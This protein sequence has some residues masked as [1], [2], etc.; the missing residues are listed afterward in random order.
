MS[1]LVTVSAT[2]P[3]VS[4]DLASCQERGVF[5]FCGG[6]GRWM[7]KGGFTGVT[8]LSSFGRLLIWPFMMG[9]GR[10]EGAGG[11]QAAGDGGREREQ[12]G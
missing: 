6:L 3:P 2:G 1:A 7:W 10:E 11:A 9:G 4:A 8:A 5:V 12:R